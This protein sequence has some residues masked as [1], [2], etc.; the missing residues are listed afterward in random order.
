MNVK[1]FRNTMRLSLREKFVAWALGEL[2]IFKRS[3]WGG[4]KIWEGCLEEVIGEGSGYVQTVNACVLVPVLLLIPVSNIWVYGGAQ[5]WVPGFWLQPDPH[6]L[7]WRHLRDW[8]EGWGV[9]ILKDRYPD[10]APAL[11]LA[12]PWARHHRAEASI[13]PSPQKV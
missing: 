7:C 4:W 8:V 12:S 5:N 1:Q 3:S 2:G 11:C 9:V 13:S 6:H 10:K